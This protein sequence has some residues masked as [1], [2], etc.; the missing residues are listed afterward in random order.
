MD[1]ERPRS[2]PGQDEQYRRAMETFGA[3]LGRLAR[4]YEADPDARRDL[5]QDIHLAVWRSFN[6]F[7]GRCTVRT[8]VYRVAHNTAASHVTRAFRR[9]T[10]AFVS[11]DEIEDAPERAPFLQDEAAAR[12]Q[13]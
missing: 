9:R 13:A 4:A 5:L 11:L 12:R 6:R 10:H 3:A 1:I 8:W 2:G 7:Y